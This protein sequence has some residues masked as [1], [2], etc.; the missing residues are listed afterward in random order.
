MYSSHNGAVI[1]SILISRLETYLSIAGPVRHGE[2][3]Q[4]T[5]N[6]RTAT[7]RTTELASPVRVPVLPVLLPTAK[8]EC[9]VLVVLACALAQRGYMAGV[10]APSSIP[11]EYVRHG[12]IVLATEWKA[13]LEQN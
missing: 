7:V 2:Y 4:A 13:S 3:A 9:P 1:G 11:F 10:S 8:I 6:R 12:D 5:L